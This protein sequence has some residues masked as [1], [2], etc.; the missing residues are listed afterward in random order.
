MDAVNKK[1]KSAESFFTLIELLVVI[2]IIAILASMLLPALN[3]ARESGRKAACMNNQKQI[4][5]ALLN[6]ANTYNSFFPNA[7]RGASGAAATLTDNWTIP[8]SDAKDLPKRMTAITTSSKVYECPSLVIRADLAIWE[9]MYGLRN[10][11][12]DPTTY[13]RFWGGKV[14]CF[15]PGAT[16]ANVW[17]PSKAII[18]GD[19]VEIGAT[20]QRQRFAMYDNYNGGGSRSIPHTRHGGNAVFGFAD[21]HVGTLTGA[22]LLKGGTSLAGTYCFTN[23]KTENFGN[24]GQ[25]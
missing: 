23:Y 22:E 25:Y 11:N 1:T 10:R 4:M 6:Y 24:V 16:A 12:Q 5:L 8:L 3:K 14:K 20:F 7:A 2:A 18:L 19:T 9:Q 13:F 21:G 15:G 17:E